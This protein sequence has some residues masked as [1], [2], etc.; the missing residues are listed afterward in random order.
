MSG[1]SEAARAG[2][3]EQVAETAHHASLSY[4]H[5]KH[6]IRRGGCGCCHSP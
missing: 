4:I 6:A 3:D 5:H 1:K 2:W